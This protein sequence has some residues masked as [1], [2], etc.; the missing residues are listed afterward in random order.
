VVPPEQ[1]EQ[2][3]QEIVAL[4]ASIQVAE[5]SFESGLEA[6]RIARAREVRLRAQLRLLQNR[7]DEMTRRELASIEEL[8]KLEEEDKTDRLKRQ[9][10]ELANP[11]PSSSYAPS[12]CL[13]LVLVLVL[14]SH[15]A[16]SVSGFDWSAVDFSWEE[17]VPQGSS[18]ETHSQV[19]VTSSGS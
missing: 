9:Q 7:R 12:K 3:Q 1:F 11:A 18:G 13:V 19:P 5:D 2:N 14:I 8:E 6:A 16:D 10:S 15:R 4:Q 17:L